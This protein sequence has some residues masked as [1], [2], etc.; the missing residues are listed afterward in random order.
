METVT[1]IILSST[2][3]REVNKLEPPKI[4]LADRIG[5]IIDPIRRKQAMD[6]LAA[7]SSLREWEIDYPKC[8][9]HSED[10][11]DIC[12]IHCNLLKHLPGSTHSA[13]IVSG[14]AVIQ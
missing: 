7:E 14:K 5:G 2:K 10:E 6:Y 13:Q 8:R 1:V 3:C 11:V 4:S 9:C 12:R